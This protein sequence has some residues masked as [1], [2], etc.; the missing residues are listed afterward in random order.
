[1]CAIQPASEALTLRKTRKGPQYKAERKWRLPL[2][3]SRY[4]SAM[5]S[6]AILAQGA[7]ISRECSISGPRGNFSGRNRTGGVRGDKE[8]EI[9]SPHVLAT[10]CKVETF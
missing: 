3:A 9:P 4:S 8:E 6:V 2:A 7:P 5:T 10:W 1:M